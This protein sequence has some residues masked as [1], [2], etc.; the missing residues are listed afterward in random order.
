MFEKIDVNEFTVICVCGI[1]LIMSILFNQSEL[2]L[3]IGGGLV[4]YIGGT[5]AK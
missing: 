1:G 2:A 4:G 3:S 5:K